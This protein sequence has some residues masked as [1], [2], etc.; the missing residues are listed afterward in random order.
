MSLILGAGIQGAGRPVSPL[1]LADRLITLAQDADRAGYRTEAEH[2]VTMVYSV[3]DATVTDQPATAQGRRARVSAPG[4]HFV[5]S[6]AR[7][8]QA[9]LLLRV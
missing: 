1:M 3:L 5:P 4:R 2:L 9:P 8:A 6:A 7:R